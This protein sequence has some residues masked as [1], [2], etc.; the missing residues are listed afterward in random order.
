MAQATTE[1]KTTAPVTVITTSGC[2]HC[3][4]A[5]EALKEAGIPYEEVELS[6]NLNLLN[7]IKEATGRRTVPQVFLNGELL[8]GASEVVELL[9][10]GQMQKLVQQADKPALPDSLRQA[11]QA[12]APPAE[13]STSSVL[14]P[15]GVSKEEYSKLRSMAERMHSLQGGVERKGH[16]KWLSAN[17]NTFTLKEATQWVIQQKLTADSPAALQLVAQLQQAHLL[18]V[19]EGESVDLA[20]T[21]LAPNSDLLVRLTADTPKARLGQTL[22]GQLPWYGSARGASEVA[23]GLRQ[24]ILRLYD[25]H[26]S[27]DGRQVDYKALAADPAFQDYVTA[28]AELQRVDLTSLSREERMAFFINIYNALVVHALTTFGPAANN[29]LS[30][31]HWFGNIKYNIGGLDFSSN[32]IE[33][34]VLRGNAPS[35]ASIPVLVGKPQLAPATFKDNDPRSKLSVQPVDP[36]IHFAL[37]CGA[38]SCPPIKVYTPDSLEAGLDSAAAAFCEGEVQVD[39]AAGEVH[40]S[41]IFKWYAGD[42]GPQEKLLP[43][44]LQYLDGQTKADLEAL[45]KERGADKIKLSYKPYDWGVNGKT[46]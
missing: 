33:H 25:T 43:W 17:E 12:A 34:G 44:L 32:D 27:P 40:M 31:L 20:K 23:E 39:R 1:S 35:P 4:R 9:G 6:G 19:V 7:K 13:A 28:T 16:R 10:S 22:N 8:G 26:L 41:K 18:S 15:S 3:K 30:R 37:V 11:V 2:P 46:D 24:M 36:R 29:V 21:S 14:M 38:K 45:I 42:F 5:K